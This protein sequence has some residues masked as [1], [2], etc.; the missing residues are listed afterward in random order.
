MPI[1]SSPQKPQI[2]G[3]GG[4]TRDDSNSNFRTSAFVFP[5][6]QRR[7]APNFPFPHSFPSLSCK[8]LKTLFF[9]FH[10][11]FPNAFP[12][13]FCP[14]SP[15]LAPKSTKMSP[16]QPVLSHAAGR[17]K[18]RTEPHFGAFC[19]ISAPAGNTLTLQTPQKTQQASH[20][21]QL[22]SINAPTTQ[23][24]P[25][26][27]STAFFHGVSCKTR[28]KR[29]AVIHCSCADASFYDP[30][31]QFSHVFFN[32]PAAPKALGRIAAPVAAM[33]LHIPAPTAPKPEP[34]AK[35]R[36]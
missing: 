22:A 15:N 32:P 10:F 36:R 28:E 9:P 24:A 34:H 13:P 29:A 17:F 18:G 26:T 25:G 27:F 7:T 12:A 2:F 31:P 1:T 4:G 16:F 30:K 8:A 6:K 33:T 3:G 5:F 14:F 11:L 35:K 21:C 19:G 20:Y 23:A